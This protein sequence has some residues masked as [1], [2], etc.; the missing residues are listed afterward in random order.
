MAKKGKFKVYVNVDTGFIAHKP[1]WCT[2]HAGLV[3][4]TQAQADELEAGKPIAKVIRGGMEQ[5]IAAKQLEVD[6]AKAVARAA[7]KAELAA[8]AKADREVSDAKEAAATLKA[9]AQAAATKISKDTKASAK[10][11]PAKKD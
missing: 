5:A 8:E 9:E 4:I 1:E 10:K 6:E 2:P 7:I 11:A 3:E